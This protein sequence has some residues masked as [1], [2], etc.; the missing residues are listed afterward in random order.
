MMDDFNSEEDE[1]IYDYYTKKKKNSRS[2]ILILFFVLFIAINIIKI[3]NF[4]EL[5]N[6]LNK[7]IV[8]NYKE[9]FNTF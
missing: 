7:D 1:V 6:S 5:S 2:S 9:N 4:F 8:N 3:I